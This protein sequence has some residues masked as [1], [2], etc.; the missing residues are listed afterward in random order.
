MIIVRLDDFENGFIQMI[1]A[2]WYYFRVKTILVSVVICRFQNFST[3]IE[4]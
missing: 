1:W 4:K 2:V 3:Y